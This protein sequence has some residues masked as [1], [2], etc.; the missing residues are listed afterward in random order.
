MFPDQAPSGSYW[1][2]LDDFPFLDQQEGCQRPDT[3]PEIPLTSGFYLCFEVQ[4]PRGCFIFPSLLECVK[5]LTSCHG[6]KML[7]DTWAGIYSERGAKA[8][9]TEGLLVPEAPL[10]TPGLSVPSTWEASN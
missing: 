8:L 6:E 4:H 10:A 1:P 7:M 5:P 9:R 3:L 2:F